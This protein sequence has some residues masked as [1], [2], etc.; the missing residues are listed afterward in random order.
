[1]KRKD[2]NV[3]EETGLPDELEPWYGKEYE[4]GKILH[5]RVYNW[6]FSKGISS[7]KKIKNDCKSKK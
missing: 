6:L 4:H 3:N 1:L 7:N 5:K 2:S